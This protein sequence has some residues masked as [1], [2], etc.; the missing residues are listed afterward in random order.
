[1][2]ERGIWVPPVSRH[3]NNA[4]TLLLDSSFLIR[5]K[6]R[7]PVHPKPSHTSSSKATHGCPDPIH[8]PL[9]QTYTP[10]ALA[11]FGGKDGGRI[12]LAINGIAFDV[13]AGRGSYGPG[14]HALKFF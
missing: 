13:T 4:M 3:D 7:L 5:P 9:F 6:D 8:L 14:V 1:M 11:H 2:Y 10:K 12:L